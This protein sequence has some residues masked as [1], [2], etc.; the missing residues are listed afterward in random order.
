MM[1]AKDQP[2]A[3]AEKD[4]SR[5]RILSLD[6]FR[7][8]TVAG[9][10]LVNFLASFAVSP[11]VLKHSHDYCSYADT[12][13]P[14]FLFA[15]GFAFRLTFGRRIKRDGATAA[16]LR[17]VRRLL[18]LMLVSVVI[19]NVSARASNWEEL[20]ALGPGGILPELVKRNW[21]QTLMH[22]AVTSLWL[23]PVIAAGTKVRI[24]WMTGS[25]ILHVLLSY[26]FNFEWVNT[27]PNGIDGGPLA[28]LTWTI[29]AMMGTFTCDLIIANINKVPRRRLAC[30]GLCLVAAG[31]LISCGTRF[32]D[33]PPN[34]QSSL[35][36]SKLASDPVLPTEAQFQR[37]ASAKHW[38][39][40]FAEPP[41]VA[42][43]DQEQRKWNYWMMS[44][45]GGTLSYMTFSAGVSVLAYLLFYMACDQRGFHSS[46]LQTFGTNAL[47]AYVLHEMVG[48]AVKPFIPKDSPG[49]YVTLGL[50]LFFLITWTF[51]RSLEKQ[52]IFLRL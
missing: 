14:Q 27:S 36:D 3:E 38:S 49:W 39:D 13:M 4:V 25:A 30:W 28:F 42:P 45:R 2:S 33:V 47:A 16:N 10:L 51:V 1:A 12:I 31:Y 11:A 23:L 6:Q 35:S 24:L 41:F 21:F 18:G 52:K 17:M 40:W 22:I 46:F 8:Y 50:L 29:P 43:P 26:W 7:G 20:V 37:W 44:Q 34:L 48:E 9:M 5:K 19:Y 32:Y 15:V